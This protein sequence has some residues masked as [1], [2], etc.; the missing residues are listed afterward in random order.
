MKNPVV[1]FAGY[2]W[3]DLV[4]PQKITYGITN[5]LSMSQ[6]IV[7]ACIISFIIH[8][9]KLQMPKNKSIMNLF[10]L[11]T[12]YL[13]ITTFFA[14][15]QIEAW[16]KWEITIKT[17]LSCFLMLF[18]VREK[19]D[20]ELLIWIFIIS[21]FYF[22]LVLGAKGLLG[23]GGYGKTLIAGGNNSNLTE[24]STVSLI[25]ITAIP[26]VIFMQYNSLL[27]PHFKKFK[28]SAA[29]FTL[30]IMGVL[31]ATTA[32]TGLVAFAA[33]AGLLFLSS[34][35]KMQYIIIATVVGIIALLVIPDKYA[36]RMSTIKES[37]KESSAATRLVVWRWTWEFAKS[38]P[39]GGGFEAYRANYGELQQYDDN[40]AAGDGVILAR[41]YHSIYFEV[42]GEHGY[43]GFFLYFWMIAICLKS[44]RRI[45][46]L[47]KD[48]WLASCALNLNRS[49]I[50]FLVGGTFIGI[51]FQPFIFLFIVFS[52]SLANLT[53][54]EDKKSLIH[55][56]NLNKASPL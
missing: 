18:V 53:K 2:I 19:K 11:L 12:L 15:F 47:E 40:K 38:H 32:R 17:L 46:K 20:L 16:S 10:I 48:K 26:L 22:T 23:G 54:E 33:F 21:L 8:F 51:A 39:F 6:I 37:Q 1:A 30:L 27:V 24:S 50:I 9:K 36:K 41:A 44:N 34:K 13:T 35:K 49:I 55:K 45:R 29:L 43:L 7:A 4:T 31:V 28:Y 3:V 14:L 5:D 56:N 52:V 25:C 42:L